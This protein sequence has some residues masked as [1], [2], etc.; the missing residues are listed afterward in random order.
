[1]ESGGRGWLETVARRLS[2][3][4]AMT[5]DAA[6]LHGALEQAE[7]Y[8]DLGMREHA[9]NALE[10]LRDALRVLPVV[11]LRRLD[12]LLGLK[13]W[14]KARILGESLARLL[15]QDAGLWFRL[16]CIRAQR[17]DE[18]GAKAAVARCIEIDLGW[19]RRVLDAPDLAG[20]W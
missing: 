9:W 14:E 15:P 16:A 10:D 19:R 1:M 17:G 2:R 7:G 12:C 8:C 13:H 3:D 4:N 18:G 20:I 5:K 11:L 6:A